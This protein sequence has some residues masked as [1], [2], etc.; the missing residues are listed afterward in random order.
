M[1]AP[2]A[3]LNVSSKAP[4]TTA[5]SAQS[6]VE[7]K[8]IED[9]GKLAAKRAQNGHVVV[10]MTDWTY[11]GVALNWIAHMKYL[12]LTNFIVVAT[13]KKLL[14]LLGE[15]GT[16][17]EPK[18]MNTQPKG[19]ERKCKHS[20][21]WYVKHAS[22]LAAMR[23]TVMG[24]IAVTWSD[25]DCIWFGDYTS[26]LN[27]NHPGERID[28]VAQRGKHP[29]EIANKYGSIL[30]I[31]LYTLFPTTNALLFYEDFVYNKFNDA[32]YKG[33]CD[34]QVVINKVLEK[35]GSFGNINT[36]YQSTKQGQPI[37]YAKLS[38]NKI[39]ISVIAGLLPYPEFPRGILIHGRTPSVPVQTAE[40]N[41]YRCHGSIIWHLLAAKKSADKHSHMVGMGVFSLRGGWEK[42]TTW[43]QAEAF[44]AMDHI[45]NTISQSCDSPRTRFVSPKPLSS[46]QLASILGNKTVLSA[47]T[48]ATATATNLS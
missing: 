8:Q 43:A 39:N 3:N 41:K 47:A 12:G 25:A 7:I 30:S 19:R 5:L 11:R 26:W 15:Y 38:E 17:F 28:I 36:T 13:E 31:G 40:W 21:L 29:A 6:V 16:L 20:P 48:I 1:A 46:K 18:E 37:V 42:A 4:I 10:T 27:K 2:V 34:D 45:K 35:D 14:P 9:L 22:I 32:V 24:K 23:G 44:F 33:H